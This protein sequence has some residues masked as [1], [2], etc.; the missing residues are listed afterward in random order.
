[1]VTLTDTDIIRASWLDPDDEFTQVVET[2]VNVSTDIPS[3]DYTHPDNHTHGSKHFNKITTVLNF[4][5]HLRPTFTQKALRTV[6]CIAG[7]SGEGEPPEPR[8]S[9]AL[10]PLPPSPLTPATQAMCTAVAVYELRVTQNCF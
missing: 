3:R 9:P 2:S 4:H 10:A 7:V 5:F 6:A 8:F 1:M